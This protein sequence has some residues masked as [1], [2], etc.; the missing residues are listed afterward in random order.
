MS[1]AHALI[2]FSICDLLL[3]NVLFLNLPHPTN[4][5]GWKCLRKK[6][7]QKTK[8]LKRDSLCMI[9]ELEKGSYSDVYQTCMEKIRAGS[10]K[11][12]DF[13][14][15]FLRDCLTGIEMLEL[16][17]AERLL[18]KRGDLL[19]VTTDNQFVACRFGHVVVMG[20]VKIE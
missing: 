8:F 15:N 14:A 3:A 17:A 20:V 6:K 10:S 18:A 2:D 1:I 9:A 12:V 11:T 19:G 16:G 5:H 13:P 7:Q 4:T